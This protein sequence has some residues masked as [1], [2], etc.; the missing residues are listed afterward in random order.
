MKSITPIIVIAVCIAM[1]FMYI[2]PTLLE[3][4]ALQVKKTE[5]SDVLEKAKELKEKRDSL[6]QEYDSIPQTEIE[7]L[8]K[9]IPATFNSESFANDVNVLATKYNLI[10][11]DFRVSEPKVEVRDSSAVST[12]T[13]IYKTSLINMKVTGS[14]E[15]FIRFLSDVEQNLHLTDVT[16]LIIQ[17]NMGQKGTNA[18]MDYSLE[19]RTY[20]LR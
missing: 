5:F 1:Y 10:L 19:L 17:A 11:R 16:G 14:Y 18:S 2:N 4:K 8:N 6:L 13:G 9:I 12:G 7:K 20:S 3:V 15:Q